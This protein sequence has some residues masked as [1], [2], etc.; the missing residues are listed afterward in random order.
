[1]LA[2]HAARLYVAEVTVDTNGVARRNIAGNYFIQMRKKSRII[3]RSSELPDLL[4]LEERH[5]GE[6]G[7]HP[8]VDLV[9]SPVRLDLI[10]G[11]VQPI[12]SPSN[13]SKVPSPK[14]P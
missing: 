7:L 12:I 13:A 9:R 14:S 5:D 11:A 1:V 4:R 3:P 2:G 8:L 10:E 6:R